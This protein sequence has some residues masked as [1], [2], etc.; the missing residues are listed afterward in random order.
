MQLHTHNQIAHVAITHHDGK[1][2]APDST[3]YYEHARAAGQVAS[4][5][6]ESALTCRFGLGWVPRPDGMGHGINGIGAD[7]MDVFS[8]RRDVINEKVARELVPR[9]Q[10][11]YGR[12]PNQ[13]E[14]AS[15]MDKANLRTRRGKDDV[16]DRDAATRGW[17][18]EAA[19]KA[20]VDLASLYRRVSRLGRN[21]CAP[22][23]AGPQLT[24][25]D[26][27]RAAHKALEK[28]SRENS[29]WMRADLIASKRLRRPAWPSAGC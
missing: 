10:A 11:E 20:G 16:I 15:L 17:Q 14:L 21:G 5:H 12:A 28:C 19:Q 4:V 27:T 23:D 2:R 9:F 22:P 8:H 7:L 26:I 18:A 29:K 13:R 24:R 25:D 6:A 3:A 1:G